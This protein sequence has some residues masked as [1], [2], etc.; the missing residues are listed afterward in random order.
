M[1]YHLLSR[2]EELTRVQAFYDGGGIDEV[3]SAEDAH[4][5]RRNI[6]QPS[7]RACPRNTENETIIL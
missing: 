5:M 7:T 1:T 3:T 4:Q 6:R 2:I